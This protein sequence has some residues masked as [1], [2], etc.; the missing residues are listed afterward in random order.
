MST[1]LQLFREDA[2]RVA[3]RRSELFVETTFERC[4][5]VA[6][7]AAY[8]LKPGRIGGLPKL[9]RLWLGDML[10]P[11]GKLPSV[12]E[13]CRFTG[14]CGIARDLSVPSLLAAY[15]QGLFP[16]G[17]TAPVKWYSPVTRCVLFFNDIRI[18]K[19]VRRL[20][21]KGSYR[22]TFDR[23]FDSV[24]KACAARRPG[25]WHVTW[26][27]PEIMHAY[28][29][30][31]DA[32]HAHSYEVW[33]AAG[34]LVGGGYGVAIGGAFFGESQ[35]SRERNTS[36]I[37]QAVLAWHLA[38]WGFSY[39]DSKWPA[40]TLLNMGFCMIPRN[41]FIA[42]TRAAIERPTKRGAW[43]I[44]GDLATIAEWRPNSMSDVTEPP[45]IGTTE[46]R[47]RAYVRRSLL[48]LLPAVDQATVGLGEAML[49]LV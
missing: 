34:E 28:A 37:G 27:T 49:R 16:G 22:V 10:A 15:K 29:A 36:K 12:N 2:E 43:D 38:N 18:E 8:A 47:A 42:I 33:N 48:P 21:R 19:N 23:D 5:R 17:H 14:L 25:K 30:L 41:E 13:A 31:H 20:M 3:A 39:D 9:A 46:S 4:E 11:T 26:I 32:G 1:N 44:E 45:A 40:P 7:A 6:L 24:I 35:F